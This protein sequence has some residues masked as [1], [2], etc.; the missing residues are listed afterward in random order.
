MKTIKW[1][2]YR[3]LAKLYPKQLAALF[4]SHRY[5]IVEASTKSGKTIG[6]LV[7]LFERA[8]AARS[9]KHL[10]WV[11]P[12]AAQAEIAFRRLKQ[13]APAKVYVANESRKT[14]QLVNG[15]TIW[16]KSGDRPDTLYGEDVVAAVID[17][18]S[19]CKEGTWHAVRSTVTA[20]R[21]PVRII[22]NVRGRTNWFY[23]L[24]RKA[25]RGAADMHYAK[26]TA[27][28]AIEAGVLS[29]EE[30]ADAERQ[31]PRAVFDE[32]YRAEPSDNQSNPLGFEAIRQCVAPKSSRAPVVWGWDLGKSEDFTVGIALD[33]QGAV[34][35][36]V[37]R[38]GPWKA[39][40]EA[41]IAATGTVPALVDST[42][43]GDPILELLQ[44]VDSSQYEGFHFSRISKQ[45]LMMGL[46]VA[47]QQ[48]RVSFPEGPIT[49]ELE[50]F[51]Y[52]VEESTVRY[53]APHGLYDDCVCALALAV[54]HYATEFDGVPVRLLGSGLPPAN[55]ALRKILATWGR[56]PVSHDWKM[57]QPDD[58]LETSH[59]DGQERKGGD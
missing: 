9:G 14:I 44:Q 48:N 47:I 3:R 29:A 27:A 18:A 54:R 56:P 37:R 5:A 46:A 15:V 17:E 12:T 4:T 19:R 13:M 2:I 39:T 33:A 8:L 1:I 24:A 23:H 28:D 21:G 32:L 35:R 36:I 10:W 31:L 22:G 6:A 30:I 41:I 38:R 55:N 49:E 20:T 26:I 25:Q 45:Q 43:V 57:P 7:W 53:R 51:E 40:I 59:S 50:T 52:T 42:G 34:C 11:A 58:G 16:F